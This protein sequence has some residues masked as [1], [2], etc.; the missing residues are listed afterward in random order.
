MS[1]SPSAAITSRFTGRAKSSPG[2]ESISIARLW[3]TGWAALVGGW[4]RC[5]PANLSAAKALGLIIPPTLLARSDGGDRVN[6]YGHV[7]YLLRCMS[8]VLALRVISRAPNNPVAFGAKRTSTSR[9]PPLNRSKMTRTGLP[10][11]P[12]VV[13]PR[14]TRRRHS[15][16]SV[17]LA[18]AYATFE[19]GSPSLWPRPSG[20][21]RNWRPQCGFLIQ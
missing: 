13:S 20:R 6:H 3:R 9:Q 17:W 16:V 7:R 8:P 19:I 10:A 11:N 14:A 12:C 2:T 15:T 1:R 18:A 5:R 4:S 21:L